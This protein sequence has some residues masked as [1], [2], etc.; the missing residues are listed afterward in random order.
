[1]L[2]RW[3]R[4][5]RVGPR[6]L[7]VFDEMTQLALVIIG[8]VLFGVDLRDDV[9]E[10][11]GAAQ[12]AL[13]VL[14]TAGGRAGAAAALGAD[15]AQPPFQRRHAHPAHL[16]RRHPRPERAT[17]ETRRRSFLKMLMEARDPETG[18]RM[19]DRQ[20]HE[21]TLGMLQQGHDTVGETLAWTWYLRVAAS[22]GRAA[23]A[24][25]GLASRRRS[26]AGRRR[27]RRGS[28][29]TNMV[30]QESHAA[31]SAGVGHPA[32]RHPTTMDR[33]L[34]DSRR[35]HDPAQPLSHAPPSRRLGEPRGVRPRAL[36]AP[37]R[38]KDRPRHA[39][40]PFGGGPRLCMGADMATMEMLLIMAMVVQRFRAA[41]G[42][43]DIAKSPSASSTWCRVIAFA[44]RS[45]GSLPPFADPSSVE[46][47]RV[48]GWH[49]LRPA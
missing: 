13:A 25:R 4:D 8:D 12:T 43:R 6:E 18:S 3:E 31:V 19:T 11:A 40:F 21:E 39:Y 26:H 20:L 29:Y 10:M 2:A 23:A 45:S 36:S 32:R 47:W 9:P 27:S 37:A 1:M 14:K 5:R 41:A 42:L 28:S 7:R 17:P 34:S 16:H 24:R 46:W 44:R 48:P 22:R 49:P 35:L 38:S 33:R 30:L 15:T